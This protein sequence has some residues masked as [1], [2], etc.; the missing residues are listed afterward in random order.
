M[1]KKV[2]NIDL[3]NKIDCLDNKI[4]IVMSRLSVSGNVTGCCDCQARETKVYNELKDFLETKMDSFKADIES[5]LEQSNSNTFVNLFE[6]YKQ[7]LICNLELIIQHLNCWNGSQE[8]Q[9]TVNDIYKLLVAHTS[10]LDKLRS[11]QSLLDSNV[12]ATLDLTKEISNS[13]A[14]LH[15]E[16]EVIKHQLLLEEELR[17]YDNEID[18]LKQQV[19]ETLGQVNKLITDLTTMNTLQLNTLQP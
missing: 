9:H 5:K 1:F 17:K 10:A 6:E 2:S 4:D 14:V 12:S 13:M 15:Y 11:S 18:S 8:P 3:K 7:E 16:N 19:E